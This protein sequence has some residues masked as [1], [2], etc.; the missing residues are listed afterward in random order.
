M[1]FPWP[2]EL[3]SCTCGHM[4][5]QQI[6][7]RLDDR[8]VL[9]TG[10]RR[11]S[12]A[13][14]SSPCEPLSTGVMS[15]CRKVNVSSFA[16]SPSF[17]QVSRWRLPRRRAGS[18]KVKPLLGFQIS[19][20]N[21]WS[22]SKEGALRLDGVCWRPSGSTPQKLGTGA[23]YHV[24]MRR[25]VTFF[26]SFFQPFSNESSLHAAIEHLGPYRRRD[27]QP[28]GN[29]DLGL[30]APV[31]MGRWEP[32]WQPLHPISGLP[33]VLCPNPVNGHRRLSLTFNAKRAADPKWSFDARLDLR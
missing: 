19:S 6:A 31:A 17:P 7:G 14:T 15:C 20:Q 13:P 5:L 2:P 28:A 1:E 21:R 12:A 11:A 18:K 23:D 30:F 16:S 8:F 29:F 25:C 32:N 33:S 3:A 27:R 26:T 4:G 22:P 24:T 9:L 10:G